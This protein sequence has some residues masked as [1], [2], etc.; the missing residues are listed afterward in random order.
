MPTCIKGNALLW[1]SVEPRLLPSSSPPGSSP[2]TE[3]AHQL[4]VWILKPALSLFIH[5]AQRLPFPPKCVFSLA[6]ALQPNLFQ[7]HAWRR[8]ICVI[9]KQIK[10]WTCYSMSFAINHGCKVGQVGFGCYSCPTKKILSY[11][12]ASNDLLH[13]LFSCSIYY[14]LLGCVGKTDEDEKLRGAELTKRH[15]RETWKHQVACTG[16][17]A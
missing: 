6:L 5:F 7:K 11:C 4:C 17:D 9:Y 14:M 16:W 12:S 1:S 10:C 15:G 8:L 3:Q 13:I 2:T